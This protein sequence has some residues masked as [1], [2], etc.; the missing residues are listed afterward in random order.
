MPARS[1][2]CKWGAKPLL[3]ACEASQRHC[4][5]PRGWEDW[6]GCVDPRVRRS[7]RAP[8]GQSFRGKGSVA[9]VRL[10]TLITWFV[11]ALPTFGWA[12]EPTAPPPVPPAP[13]TEVA[14][15]VVVTA[16]K[17]AEPLER[18]GAAIT[19]ITGDELRAYN[20]PTI[21]DA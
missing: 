13:R 11:I 7:T 5:P 2:H 14:E 3:E 8:C 19:V 12:Q 18:L 4:L 21:G 9:M 16:T 6:G 1:R 15:P 20:Y 10:F 17:I